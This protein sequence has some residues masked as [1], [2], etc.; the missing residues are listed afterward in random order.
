MPTVGLQERIAGAGSLP[1]LLDAAYDAFEE[2]LVVIRQHDDPRNDF[3]VPMVIAGASAGN[4]RDAVLFA[5]SLPP[6][7]LHPGQQAGDDQP[8]ATAQAAASWLIVLCKTLM[9]RLAEAGQSAVDAGDRDACADAARYAREIHG[10]MG[11]GQR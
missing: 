9:G 6:R 1:E 5:P 7:P 3:F 10:L 11:G 4:G 8:P 2:M